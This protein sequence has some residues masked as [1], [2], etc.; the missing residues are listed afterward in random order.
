[1][2]AHAVPG[3]SAWQGHADALHAAAAVRLGR[4]A[5][6][7]VEAHARLIVLDTLGC[8]L[9][10]RTAPE[11]AALEAALSQAEPGSLRLPGDSVLTLR[12]ALQVLAIAPTWHEACEG[13]A[14]AH[15][16]P[17]IATLAAVWPLALL[18]SAALGEALDAFVLGY[19]VA[20]RA[21]GWLRM[22]PGLHVDGNWPALGAAAGA[23]GL[24]GL[25]AE[26]MRHAIDIAAC[27]LPQSLYLPIRTG[28]S[29]RNVYLA[30]SAALGLDAAFAAQAGIEA[31]PDAL[32]WYAQHRCPAATEPLPAPEVPLLLDGYLK[33]YAA[34][35]H[36]HYGALAAQRLRSRLQGDTVGISRIELSVYEEATVYC[37]NPQP[38][39]LL[40]AQFSLG[41]GLAAALRF[42][43]L[44]AASYHAPRFQDAELRRLEALVQVA[45]DPERTALRQRG[46]TLRVTAGGMVLEERVDDGD[47]A[48]LLTPAGVLDKFVLNAGGT[49][50]A[51]RFGR[52]LLDSPRERLLADLW[53]LL[54]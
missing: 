2:T 50:A 7:E 27:Q 47:P 44:D 42:G 14:F 36:V 48:L 30:R 40:A 12:A 54:P 17:G 11:V 51:R 18:R 26:Q 4:P 35:R 10:G 45:I 39:T 1:M 38:Q 32:A 37:N 49:D 6:P 20:A 24:L 31:P 52:A 28:R 22:A 5:A 3:W 8:A 23:A 21:G 46:A 53:N 19:E 25:G 16:R 29:V 34:V 9:A 13:H 41:F 43:A 15:G 33:P